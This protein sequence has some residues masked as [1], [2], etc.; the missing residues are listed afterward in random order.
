LNLIT[1]SVTDLLL[2]ILQTK[3]LNMR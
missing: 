1:I 3:Q 2:H